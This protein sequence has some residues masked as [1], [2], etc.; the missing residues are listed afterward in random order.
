MSECVR[1]CV[2]VCVRVRV[3]DT[4]VMGMAAG[5]MYISCVG[6]CVYVFMNPMPG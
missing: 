2:C 1:A 4:L 5:M 6:L 3:C